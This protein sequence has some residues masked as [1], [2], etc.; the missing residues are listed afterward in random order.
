MN[1]RARHGERS[2]IMSAMPSGGAPVIPCVI[3]Y[4]LLPLLC[5]KMPH[6]RY[7]RYAF[8]CSASSFRHT[9]YAIRYLPRAVRRYTPRCASR[10]RARRVI[11]A[12]VL[13]AGEHAACSLPMLREQRRYALPAPRAAR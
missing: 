8:S 2:A 5:A 3:W 7:A 11:C 13:C 4:T 10:C 12:C 6:E 9:P 1:I